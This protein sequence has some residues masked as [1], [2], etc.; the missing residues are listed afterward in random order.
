M[1]ELK[2]FYKTKHDLYQ[3]EISKFKINH[4]SDHSDLSQ[5]KQ[6]LVF[7]YIREELLAVASAKRMSNKAKALS[8]LRAYRKE[9]F[10]EEIGPSFE[11]E[12]KV[13]ILKKCKL[14]FF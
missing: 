1:L 11:K 14:L 6:Y 8:E 10:A 2:I 4:V 13:K 7:S 9:P 5:I 3:L 12:T